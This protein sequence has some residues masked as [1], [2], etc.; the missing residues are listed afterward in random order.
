MH[1]E[2]IKGRGLHKILQINH[3]SMRSA[4]VHVNDR[5]R[6]SYH[7]QVAVCAMYIKLNDAYY[8]SESELPILE[9]LQKGEKES[10]MHFYWKLTLNSF[11]CQPQEMVTHTTPIRRQQPTNCLSVFGHFVGLFLKGFIFKF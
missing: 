9:Q 10:E 8:Q 1:G 7:L 11:K 3:L 6:A 4:A 2:L 5:K